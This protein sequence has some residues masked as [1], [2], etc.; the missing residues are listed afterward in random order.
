MNPK[1]KTEMLFYLSSS[2]I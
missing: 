2:R 1:Q